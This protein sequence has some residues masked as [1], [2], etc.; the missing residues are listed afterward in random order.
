MI[1]SL[2]RTLLAG[3]S[4]EASASFDYPEKI[5]Q[6]GT[7]VLLR[8][9]TDYLIDQANKQGV[10]KGRIV[11]VKST[12]GGEIAA[13]DK[14]DNLYTVCVR[15]VENGDAVEKEVVCSAISRV[16]AADGH[17]P[18]I[19]ACA[20]DP[21][22]QVVI[23]N[24]TEVGIQFV[25]ESIHDTPPASY[26]GKLLAFLWERYLFFQGAVD[27]GLVIVPTEL[28]P[29]NAVLLKKILLDLA[30]HNKLPA[31]FC[32]WLL[33]ANHFCNSLVDRIVPGK[34][35]PELK[36]QLAQQLGYQDDLLIMAESY[37]L[38]AIEGNEQV[39]EVLSFEQSDEGVIIAP[40]IRKYRERKLRLL[41]GTHTLLCGL[42]FLRGVQ[43]VSDFMA[44]PE[45]ES[46]ITSL[47]LEEVI[48]GMPFAMEENEARTF[49]L[50]V[51]DRFRNP[52]IR[53]LWYNITLQYTSKMKLR[54][55]PL[56]STYVEKEGQLPPIMVQCLAAWARFTWV[57]KVAEGKYFGSFDGNLYLIQD[58]FAPNL[59]QHQQ[60]GKA[61][62]IATLFADSTIWGKDL[63]Q[64]PGLT[65]AVNGYFLSGTVI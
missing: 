32:D 6:F 1:P 7:G 24:T 54:V 40:D 18:E 21:N 16:L 23:S 29:D 46:L 26:P 30:N 60:A 53:H 34:P 42:A 65:E 12:Q 10:F 2:N 51:L 63:S 43:T 5:I 64:I 58:D 52:H 49:A 56:L 11:V 35:S 33:Q 39:R 61:G 44:N 38:W 8:G 19:L 55:L 41:N 25:A 48:P 15:G 31:A 37:R 59:H 9:L 17:W 50:Q 28:V 36:A 47:M 57:E 13:F 22:F 20:S 62:Y 4:P 14:Q 45:Q 27:K 3:I